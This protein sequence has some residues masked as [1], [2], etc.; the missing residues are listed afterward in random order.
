MTRIIQ[1]AITL[2]VFS[3]IYISPQTVV[4]GEPAAGL[5]VRDAVLQHHCPQCNS[6]VHVAGI[7]EISDSS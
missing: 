7:A 1:F 4:A 3:L 5:Q 6:G 2:A